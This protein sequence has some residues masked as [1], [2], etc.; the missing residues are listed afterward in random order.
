MLRSANGRFGL[1]GVGIK[2]GLTG[3]LLTLQYW[4][5][6]RRPSHES[7]AVKTNFVMTGIYAGVAAHNFSIRAR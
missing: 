5:I 3:G 7:L 4:G 6:R 2:A 1:K